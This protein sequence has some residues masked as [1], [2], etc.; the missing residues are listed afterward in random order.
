MGKIRKIILQVIIVVT[1]IAKFHGEGGVDCEG[2]EATSDVS[3]Q[4]RK[5]ESVYSTS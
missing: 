4:R 2:G 1:G 5:N 3:R